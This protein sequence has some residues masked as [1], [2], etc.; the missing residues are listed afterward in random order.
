MSILGE[1]EATTRCEFYKDEFDTT[2]YPLVTELTGDPD[3]V[4]GD[5]DNDPK[6]IILIAENTATYYSQ[7]NEIEHIYS[8]Y[9]EMIY[10]YYNTFEI[11]GTIAHEFCHLIWFNYEF[12]EVHFALEGLA[13]YAT[14]YAGYFTQYDNLSSRTSYFF[15]RP[16][17]SLIYFDVAAKDYGGA[18][19]FTF[20]LAE[21]FGLQFL[22][23][24][25]QQEVDG[26]LGI[27]T[28]LQ[29]S[30]YDISFN[31]LFL[32]WITALTIDNVE[33][34]DGRFGFRE[35]DISIIEISNAIE[36]PYTRN[37]QNLNFYGLRAYKLTN[38]ADS[39]SVEI[40]GS[41]LRFFGLSIAFHDVTGWHIQQSQNQ[42]S[43]LE[44]V[45][46]TSIDTAYLIMSAIGSNTPSGNIDFGSGP[47]TEVDIA[48]RSKP[49][50]ASGSEM[51]WIIGGVT[52]IV[53]TCAIGIFILRER[54]NK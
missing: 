16:D 27:E 50:I 7:Y 28:T 23:D 25:V 44:N 51:N 24:L 5:I 19:L 20:Y 43:I 46:G 11:I 26:A 42:S 40:S 14:Y 17:D 15:D 6:I 18:Y 10:I 34:A 4:I 47:S 13:E 33:I 29:E 36:I 30:G 49:T 35:F 38:P 32:D 41:S 3:G 9:C 1:S 22:R 2:I 52:L 48:I 54:V 8:N 12:D 21:R 39:F 53:A 31:S 45:Y 37:R